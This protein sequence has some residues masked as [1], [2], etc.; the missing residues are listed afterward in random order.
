MQRLFVG[1]AD[2]HAGPAADGFKPLEHL[3][4]S[5]GVAGLGATSA[6][7]DLERSSAFRF[8]GPEQIIVGFGFG[9]FFQW[10]GHGSSC[11]AREIAQRIGRSDY[12]TDG[13]KK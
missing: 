2:I 13:L 4:V 10:L 8:R 9:S 7:G 5:R 12:A 3:D 1:T 11:V 6:A